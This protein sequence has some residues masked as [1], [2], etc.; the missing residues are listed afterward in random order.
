[1]LIPKFENECY[2]YLKHE[3]G[4]NFLIH[5]TL[6]DNIAG[7]ARHGIIPRSMPDFS[8]KTTDD[9]RIDQQMEASCFS[10]SF[11]NYRMLYSK[12]NQMPDTQFVILLFDIDCLNYIDIDKV[13]YCAHNA[14]SAEML[15][16]SFAEKTGLNAAKAMFYDEDN[17]R[18][19]HYLPSH[20]TTDPQAE[21][22][23]KAIV[24]FAAVKE[25][26]INSTKAEQYITQ[27]G[28]SGIPIINSEMFFRP[29]C[30]YK[31]WS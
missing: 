31:Y 7:I 22:Q 10:I 23:I 13:A 14:A 18:S 9:Y 29:R 3:R 27:L 6:L 5:F 21:V 4:V 16:L 19:N 24:P 15:N 8:I 11:P 26:H 28:I 20:F 30:D 25:I 1:M 17:I 12:R 2:N